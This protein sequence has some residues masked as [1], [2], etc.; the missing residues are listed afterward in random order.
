[1]VNFL[2]VHGG[3]HGAWCWD[4]LIPY[5]NQH[6]MVA[7]TI[8]VDLCGHG[9]RQAERPQEEI[10]IEDYVR[11]IVE[12]ID[13]RDLREVVLVGHSLAGISIPHVA[14]Q[15]PDRI[16][17]L[18]YL[19]TTNPPIGSCVNDMLTHPLS[20]ISRNVDLTAAFCS[21]LDE[22]TAAWLVKN[23]GPQPPG[24]LSERVTRVAGPPE[25]PSTYVLLE[26]DEVLP[27]EYQ[28]LQAETIKADEIVR[29]P[30]GHS[31][32]ASRPEAL[33]NLLCALVGPVTG[34]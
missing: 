33:A 3:S 21:D 17:R 14:A 5:L 6:A 30:A 15:R 1:M 19:S 23:L 12:E 9:A 2:L 25:V 10:T 32:F 29:F 26:Q 11:S 18:V 24:V 8:A 27:P 34:D 16:E 20:P 13:A 22:E 7:S 4:R 31:A 28:L